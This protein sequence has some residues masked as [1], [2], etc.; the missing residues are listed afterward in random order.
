MLP[1]VPEAIKPGG[2]KLSFGSAWTNV[3]AREDSYFL[4]YEMLE[5]FIAVSYGVNER[6]GL[7]LGFS[8]RNYFG[9]A[10]DNSIEEF[11]DLFGLSQH[12]RDQA[13][14]NDTRI[15]RYDTYGNI[16]EDTNDISEANNNNLLFTIKF[17]LDHGT[18]HMPAVG[19][20]GIVRYGLDTPPREHDD[21][22]IDIGMGIGFSKRWADQWYSYHYLG[23]T[24]YGQAEVFNVRLE[25][26]TFFGM[27][28][29]AWHW[30][31]NSSILLQYMVHEGA[32]KDFGSMSDAS[33]E[34]DLGLKWLFSDGDIIE[35]GLI[36]NILIVDNSPD[37]GIHL[38]YEHIW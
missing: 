11:H 20:S 8:Q 3:W 14:H 9:G 31:K 15:V 16:I 10:M 28:A 12:G 37:F 29:L 19:I 21:G 6:L 18:K 2:Y 23:L 26:N 33:H 30:R 25:K 4:D 38:A 32:L 1:T 27:T 7:A 5:S 22:T 36:E 17:I 13:P 34:V 24:R 35:I